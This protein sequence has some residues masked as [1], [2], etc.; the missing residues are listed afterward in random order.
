MVRKSSSEV[1]VVTKGQL[2]KSKN[3]LL[4]L[5]AFTEGVPAGILSGIF[6]GLAT[7]PVDSWVYAD[8]PFS[9]ESFSLKEMK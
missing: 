5:A 1:G 6:D 8:K 3:P 7:G 4:L 2:K 9:K